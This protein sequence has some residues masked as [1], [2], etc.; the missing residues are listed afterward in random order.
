[1]AFLT[2]RT[3]WITALVVAIGLLGLTQARRGEAYEANY[4]KTPVGTVEVKR[5]PAAKALQAEAEGD[6][7]DDGGRPFGT[8]FR[9]IK[10]QRLAM[11]VPVEVD[12]P[13]NRMRF[14]VPRDEAARVAEGLHGATVLAL[15][16][17]TV[18]SVGMH[19]RYTPERFEAGKRRI[20]AW[21]AGQSEWKAEGSPYAVYWNGPN[22]TPFLN[23]S[24][25]HQP[26]VPI[27]GDAT[28]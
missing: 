4:P 21:L 3:A 24:E 13:R 20:D 10:A 28:P 23:R 6:S 9:E 22:A 1:M 17:R 7:F 12:A 27:A 15:P 25:V 16:E 5:L 26:I 2:G 18:L 14:F 8:L 11:T 19:G